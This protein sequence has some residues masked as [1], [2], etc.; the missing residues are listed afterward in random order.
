MKHEL[1]QQIFEKY[2]KI[3]FHENPCGGSR[4]VPC[5]RMDGQTDMTKLIVAFRNF[6]NASKDD[7]ILFHLPYLPFTGS[8]NRSMVRS[9]HLHSS[10]ISLASL[11]NRKIF[12]IFLRS[13]KLRQY[14]CVSMSTQN[15]NIHHNRRK[16]CNYR[17]GMNC[18]RCLHLV[19]LIFQLLRFVAVQCACAIC[20]HRQ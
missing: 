4:T 5:G 12:S 13:F 14:P 16:G 8:C 17:Y 9:S 11:L 3:I 15:Y 10:S 7:L 6:A 1:Y 19:L 20:G 2:P 18:A